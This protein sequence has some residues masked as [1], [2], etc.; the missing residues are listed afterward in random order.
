M[1]KYSTNKLIFSL[2]IFLQ[3]VFSSCASINMERISPSFN[4]AFDAIKGALIGYPD[5]VFTGE[6][7]NSIPYAS[8]MLKIGKGSNGLIILE[9]VSNTKYTWVSQDKVFIVIQDG[10]IIE[11][12]GLFNNLTNLTRPDLSFEDFVGG[13]PNVSTNYFFYYSYDKPFLLDLRVS[14]TLVNKGYQKVE[15]LGQTRNLLLLEETISNKQ[16]RWEKKNLFWIDPSDHFV[17]KSIQHI[18]PKLPPFILQVTKRP[19]I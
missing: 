13:S 2:L 4:S 10:R 19:K 15:I 17:W 9:S 1:K 18:S 16:I 14:A 7:I 5:P 8:A 6:I 3:F 11:T 12:E